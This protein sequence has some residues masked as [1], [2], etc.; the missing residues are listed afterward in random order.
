MK[1]IDKIAKEFKASLNVN[2][3]IGDMDLRLSKEIL[4]Q[5][6][7]L[8]AKYENHL[9]EVTC[10]FGLPHPAVTTG[11]VIENG[12]T[13]RVRFN[14]GHFFIREFAE[15]LTK[16]TVQTGHTSSLIPKCSYA[17]YAP[18]HEFF[19]TVFAPEACLNPLLLDELTFIYQW[20][21]DELMSIYTLLEMEAID[22]SQ[23]RRLVEAISVGSYALCSDLG[24]FFAEAMT[25]YELADGKNATADLVYEWA[26]R[27]NLVK[28]K[29][30]KK[31]EKKT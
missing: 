9:E 23:A 26:N 17:I 11:T 22:I 6:K 29:N 3:F 8:T 31:N 5:Y 28:E 14:M 10:E 25:V 20:H 24:E 15:D 12:W 1:K 13:C 21:V 7:R 16:R 4:E 27:W 2:A 18:T 30:F 19:H